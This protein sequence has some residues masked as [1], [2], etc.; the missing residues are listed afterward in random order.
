M[1]TN[2]Q[3]AELPENKWMPNHFVVGLLLRTHDEDG[4]IEEMVSDDEE[5]ESNT[6]EFD[7][8]VSVISVEQQPDYSKPK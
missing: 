1:W 2:V 4:I 8:M 5:M 3:G 7:E 6:D